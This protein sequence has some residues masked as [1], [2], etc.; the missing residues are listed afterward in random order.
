MSLRCLSLSSFHCPS[1]RSAGP[2][3]RLY[4][5]LTAPVRARLSSAGRSFPAGHPH[6]FLPYKAVRDGAPALQRT[7]LQR[8][9]PPFKRQ[10][11]CSFLFLSVCSVFNFYPHPLIPFPSHC[12]PSPLPSLLLCSSGSLFGLTLLDSPAPGFRHF[13]SFF[14]YFD[15]FDNLCFLLF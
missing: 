2:C 3:N 6:T 10:F 12:R 15:C 4:F 11:P 14:F 9:F 1:V 7:L 5:Q 13:V 8:S